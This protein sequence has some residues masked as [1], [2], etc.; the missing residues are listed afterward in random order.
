MDKKQLEQYIAE[1]YGVEGEHPWMKYPSYTVFRHYGS[2]KWFA[3]V[4]DIPRNKLGL[5]GS[6][7]IDVLN[8][9]CDPILIGSLR[10]EK[11]FYPAYHMSKTTWISI[12]LDGSVEDEKIK[13]LLD[14]SFHAAGPKKRAKE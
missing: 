3:L 5:A 1:Q 6:E 4:M 13:W 11:G 9:K 8:V 7:D 12:S 14:M 10:G 2:Q